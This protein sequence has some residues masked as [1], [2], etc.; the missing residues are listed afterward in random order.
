MLLII[1]VWYANTFGLRTLQSS[2]H[3]ILT[4]IVEAS[5]REKVHV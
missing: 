4:H 3:A 1:N 2:S 5:T